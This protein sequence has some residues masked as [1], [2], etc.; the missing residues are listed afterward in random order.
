MRFL[1]V[2]TLDMDPHPAA[3][4]LDDVAHAAGNVDTNLDG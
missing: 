4:V 3:R 2:D 1:A